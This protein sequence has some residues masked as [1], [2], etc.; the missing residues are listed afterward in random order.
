V[1]AL[2]IPTKETPNSVAAPL[3]YSVASHRALLI[4]NSDF[5]QNVLSI[6]SAEVTIFSAD[7]LSEPP[8]LD[9]EGFER[10]SHKADIPGLGATPEAAALYRESLIPC[11]QKVSGADE[12]LVVASNTVRQQRAT[13]Q[14]GLGRTA[15]VDFVHSDFTAENGFE[16]VW[17]LYG[18][19]SRSDIR[20]KAIFTAWRLLSPPPTNRPL[21]LCDARS[22]ADDDIIVGESRFPD[23]SFETAF[24]RFNPNHRWIYFP[25]LAND[26]IILLKQGDSDPAYPRIVPHAAF[27]DTSCPPGVAPRLSIES[28]C[29]ALWYG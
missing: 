10:V 29:L 13:A 28:R 7:R 17:P 3:N 23:F 11:F 1:A 16:T 19:P 25:T 22:V 6:A 26:E 24:I 8:R 14:P 27:D 2:T 5:S 18:K 15:P 4:E 9:A 21:A 20:R 12:I